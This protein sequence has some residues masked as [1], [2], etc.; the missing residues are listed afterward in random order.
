MLSSCA[1]G[2]R[3][4]TVAGYFDESEKLVAAADQLSGRAPGVYVTLNPVSPELLARSINKV[5]PFAK[6]TASDADI[7]SRRWL[8]LDFDPVRAAGISSTEQARQA[9]IDTDCRRRE[10]LR[11]CGLPDSVFAG[12]GNG[13]HPLIRIDLPNNEESTNLV[14]RCLE[15]VASRFS[16][17]SVDVDVRVFNAARIWK[18]YGTLAAKEDSTD[19]RP[20]RLATLLE[21]PQG[22]VVASSSVGACA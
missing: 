13:A 6:H 5:Q 20:H 17:A 15:A 12:S 18:L 9:A 4:G 22:L 16:S 10:W 21:V 1:P 11:E 14:R 3:K 2:A 7:L 19:E 8:P